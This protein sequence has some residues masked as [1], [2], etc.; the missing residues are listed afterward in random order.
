MTQA[1]RNDVIK[2]FQITH[3]SPNL[4]RAMKEHNNLSFEKI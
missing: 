1:M 2:I 4:N 3:Y